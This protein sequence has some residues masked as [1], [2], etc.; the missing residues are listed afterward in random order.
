MQ[1]NTRHSIVKKWV[2]YSELERE[3][4]CLITFL[5]ANSLGP[6]KAISLPMT[7]LVQ[8]YLLYVSPIASVGAI[9]RAHIWNN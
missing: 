3:A 2:A 1:H 7:I 4:T 6:V 9:N 8:F 5:N